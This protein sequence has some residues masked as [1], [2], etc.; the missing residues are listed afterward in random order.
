MS[1]ASDKSDKMILV[2]NGSLVRIKENNFI[3]KWFS[4]QYRHEKTIK[5]FE[6]AGYPEGSY[7]L[8]VDQFQKLVEDNISTNRKVVMKKVKKA[9]AEDTESIE[10]GRTTQRDRRVIKSKLKKDFNLDDK[11]IVKDGKT[12]LFVVKETTDGGSSQEDLDD[13]DW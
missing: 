2:I 5:Q 8:T 13:D 12:I 11:N 9:Y 1:K 7:E 3:K 4:R 10:C 6:K